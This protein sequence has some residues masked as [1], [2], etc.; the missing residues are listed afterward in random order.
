MLVV[1][2]VR[3]TRLCSVYS[4]PAGEYA[5][6]MQLTCKTHTSILAIRLRIQ[7]SFTGR[8]EQIKL[9][10][11]KLLLRAEQTNM[12]FVL[13]AL[14]KVFGLIITPKQKI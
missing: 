14:L 4:S 12:T 8:P 2:I 6:T 7:S 3:F 13:E 1:G 11:F 5:D 10:K 9:S